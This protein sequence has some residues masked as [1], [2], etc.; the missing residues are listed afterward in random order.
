M[1]ERYRVISLGQLVAAG[2][3][4]VNDNA[5]CLNDNVYHYQ[6]QCR[7]ASGS[8][9]RVASAERPGAMVS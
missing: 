2:P 4:N 1:Q 6:W 5:I 8:R 7:T 3:L 9:V